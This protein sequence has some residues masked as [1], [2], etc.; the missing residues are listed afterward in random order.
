MAKRNLGLAITDAETVVALGPGFCAGRDCHAVIETQ[1]GP[2][3]GRPIFEGSASADTGVIAGD[4]VLLK[5]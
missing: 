3:L 1:R 2:E 4:Q 5:V